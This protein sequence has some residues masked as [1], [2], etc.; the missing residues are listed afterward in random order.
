MY[1]L[2]ATQGQELTPRGLTETR[3][4]VATLRLLFNQFKSHGHEDLLDA[5]SFITMMIQNYQ[6]YRFP[7]RWRSY[8]FS[9]IL[10]IV[11]MFAAEPLKNESSSGHNPFTSNE[12]DSGNEFVNWKKVFVLFALASSPLPSEQDI[13]EIQK[14]M[15]RYGETITLA[16]F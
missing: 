1:Q 7:T 6:G 2:L 11:R 14:E 12:V 5:Q 4:E 16:G 9:T 10:N 15:K 8:S 3:L 13:D